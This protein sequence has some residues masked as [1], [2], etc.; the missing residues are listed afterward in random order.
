MTGSKSGSD[1]DPAS[2][3]RVRIAGAAAALAIAI[4]L[5]LVGGDTPG[6]RLFD[7]FQKL[8]PRAIGSDRVAVVLIDAESLRAVG[9]WPWPRYTIARLVERIAAEGAVA[10]GLDMVFP[11]TDWSSP[12]RF[13]GQY[14]ELDLA[15]AAA[16]AAL[17]SGD[18]ALARVIGTKPVVLA[19]AGVA[20]GSVDAGG[21]AAGDAAQLPIE[22]SI[23]PAPPPGVLAFPQA[24][25]SIPDFEEVARGQ[26]LVNGAPDADGIVRR[27]PLV[28]SVA[29]RATPGFALDLARV[30]LGVDAIGAR[31]GASGLA[32]VSLGDRL[33]PVDRDG[34]MRL[35]FGRIPP[36][37]V[38]S[39]VDVLRRPTRAD[40]FRGKVAIIGLASAG[41]VDI[42]ATPLQPEAYGMLVQAQAVDAILGGGALRRPGWAVP[43]EW[44]LGV[45]LALLAIA[46]VP[47]AHRRWWPLPVLAALLW[48]GGSFALFAGAGLLIDPIRPLA[49]GGAAF[50]AA[51]AAAGLEGARAQARLRAVLEQERLSAARTAGELEAA[52]DIQR[53]MLPGRASLAAL[54]PALSVD[55]LLEAAQSVGGDFYDALRLPDGRIALLVGDV[56]GK[57]VPA[58]LF[59][60]LGKALTAGALLRGRGLEAA[61]GDL[62]RDLSRDNSEAMF[63][64]LLLVLVDPLTGRAELMNAGHEN[65]LLLRAGAVA[66]LALEGGPPLCAVDDFPYVAEPLALQ[67]GD[68]LLLVSD[69]VTEAQSPDGDFFGHRRLAAVLEALGADWTPAIACSAL[70]N[71]VRDFEAGGEPSDDLTIL[72]MRWR[73]PA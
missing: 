13:V 29:G 46:L 34:R 43:A 19:R 49:I 62:A 4:L 30:A 20:A 10:I 48:V 65:P 72:A 47:R 11:E 37:T 60:A 58:A 67:P 61:T 2:L 51:A 27:V 42:V 28:A 57:G 6:E 23:T 21:V 38:I 36:A 69:G 18:V 73:G 26:G 25:A 31:P 14:P 54:D 53:G 55:A 1:V 39:A 17:P 8:H 22:A 56:T 5:A 50:A 70:A 16:I 24:L 52:R 3:R 63:V 35:H 66:A 68:G 44:A 41:T 12:A 7:R 9:P 40:R 64:T 32:A 45:V 59:M 71:A 33:L 15:A